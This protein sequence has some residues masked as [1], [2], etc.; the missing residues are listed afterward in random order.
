MMAVRLPL[1]IVTVAIL[2]C[3]A[4][5]F[6][7]IT[8]G[9]GN[10]PITLHGCPEGTAAMFNHR[11]RVAWWEGPP[12]GG[13]QYHAECRS[14]AKAFNEVLSDFSKVESK[15]K[16]LIVHDGAGHSFWLNRMKGQNQKDAEKIDW[17][18]SVWQRQS[19]DQLRNLPP[20]LNPTDGNDEDPPLQIDLYTAT[21]RWNDVKV[22]AGIEVIDQRL[23]AHGYSTNDGNVIEGRITDASTNMPL[24]AT[25]RVQS[26]NP[27]PSF[28]L[29]NAQ[30]KEIAAIT[31]DSEGRWTVK[32]VPVGRMQVSAE[33]KGFA[34]RVIGHLSLTDEPQWASFNSSLAKTASV[35]GQVLDDGGK[36]VE[37]V[38]IQVSDLQTSQRGR[39]Q[40]GHQIE[41]TTNADGH[42]QIDN[43]PACKGKI[44]VR[45]NGYNGPSL[46]EPV[47]IPQ[48]GVQIQ[49][50]QCGT[51]QATV[52]FAGKVPPQEY[53]VELV[54]EG[55]ATIGSYGGVVTIDAKNEFVFE[56]VRPGKYLI[57]GR[58]NPGNEKQKTEPKLVF[59]KRGQA[60]EVKLQAR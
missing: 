55:G 53:M 22:P 36:P 49:M 38:V 51:I 8:G 24:V 2:L 34:T 35:T 7:L 9:E 46:G 18:L 14:D 30:S 45:K 28:P 21:I 40:L 29:Q 23:E 13:G 56:N 10:D 44:H 11:G 3:P 5:T 58:P 41:V 43:L 47:T 60:A 32:N 33:A 6:A 39:Y 26:M 37:G 12:F 17:V 16:R 1:L 48:T 15:I 59:V 27:R 25:I 50:I 54:P 4:D 31:T 52:D 19:W 42:I 20:D 57:T